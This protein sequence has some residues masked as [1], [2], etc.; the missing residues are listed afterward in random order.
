MN[1]ISGGS[2]CT[3]IYDNSDIAR[4]NDYCHAASEL[5]VAVLLTFD[6]CDELQTGYELQTV[7]DNCIDSATSDPTAIDACGNCLV[8]EGITLNP[9]SSPT[10]SPTTK[11]TDAPS[12]I[13]SE[14]P[15]ISTN[16]SISTVPSSAP[17]GPLPA[18]YGYEYVGQGICQGNSLFLVETYDYL[19][20][21]GVQ[22]S[23]DCPSKCAPY[24]GTTSLRGF[25]FSSSSCRCLFDDGTDLTAIVSDNSGDTPSNTFSTNG[26]R[27]TIVDVVA[28]N[29][30][31]CYK[32]LEVI[33]GPEEATSFEYIG[34]GHCL[35]SSSLQYDYITI[36][37]GAD[38]FAVE[39]GAAC[40]DFDGIRGFWVKEGESCH[41]LFDDEAT[42]DGQTMNNPTNDGGGTDVISSSDYTEGHCYKVRPSP[43]SQPSIKPSISS[44]PSSMP[45]ESPSVSANPS[46]QPSENPS[47]S[48]SP[49]SIPSESPSVS[50]QPSSIPSESPSIS[51]NPSTPINGPSPS[52]SSS[53]SSIP[54]ESPSVSEQP[55]S[56][57]SL[58]PSISVKPSIEASSIP[59]GSPSV[60]ANPSSQPSE[61]PSI[62]HSPSSIPSESPSVSAQPSSTPSES[63]S[64]SSI[65]SIQV[66]YL[67]CVIFQLW[68]CNHRHLYLSHHKL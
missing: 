63:P 41:C 25:E 19:E 61:N 56:I 22:S 33:V 4:L 66:M 35:S 37:A 42:V 11:P 62:S 31:E 51:A 17:F 12:S 24:R 40:V 9:S 20:Y 36:S 59:S 48:S 23:Y 38:D 10:K 8:W 53:P 52:V 28:D 5:E 30:V 32:K 50:A 49:S 1:A 67:C 13:P 27:G 39:C 46:S 21:D 68:K 26:A 3:V 15:S 2:E 60:S 34:F 43:S 6:G 16:P 45:S 47:I 55:S 57:P 54:S 44:Q 7:F 18:F 58:S 29:D 14:L 64:V 65:P